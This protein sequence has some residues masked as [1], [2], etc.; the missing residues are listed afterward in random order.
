MEKDIVEFN[1]IQ[2]TRFP[3]SKS[4]SFRRYYYPIVNGRWLKGVQALHQEIWKA[5][6]GP[7]PEGC[8]I[9][10][11]DD[12]TLNNALENLECLTRKRHCEEHAA[13]FR[14]ARQIHIDSVREKAAE[15]HRSEAGR[16]W[17]AEH[18]RKGWENR[19]GVWKTCEQCG[20]PWLCMIRPNTSR[21][22]SRKCLERCRTVNRTAWENR[23]CSVCGQTYSIQKGKKQQVCSRKCAWVVRRQKMEAL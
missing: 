11:K 6:H 10:H 3:N 14:T 4:R 20:E 8:H 13:K 15:W 19:Q 22:C 16:A 12:D 17:H 1:G 5:A 7:I 23:S 9:H 18:A 21:F 2:F